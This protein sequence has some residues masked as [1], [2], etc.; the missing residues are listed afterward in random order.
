MRKAQG[1]LD[2][3]RTPPKEG[4][5]LWPYVS[6]LQ[7]GLM[8]RPD[9]ERGCRV[10]RGGLI[11]N[12]EIKLLKT[13]RKTLFLAGFTSCSKDQGVALG[14]LHRAEPTAELSRAWFE[15]EIPATQ[16]RIG[17][18]Q[19]GAA[20]SIERGSEFKTSEREVLLL[21]GTSLSVDSHKAGKRA[22]HDCIEIIAKVD[23]EATVRYFQVFDDGSE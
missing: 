22:G 16:R 21:D 17:S 18:L 1:A 8:R 6:I 2:L 5:Q 15:I 7:A 20:V 14:F 11:T 19:V 13:G 4:E 9:R 23:W 3:F 10:Y 12:H